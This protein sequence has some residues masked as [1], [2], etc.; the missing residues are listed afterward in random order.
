MYIYNMYIYIHTYI[1]ILY[2]YYIIYIKKSKSAPV[3]A[4]VCLSTSSNMSFQHCKKAQHGTRFDMLLSRSSTVDC[5]CRP[6]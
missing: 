1:Y 3:N 2:I 5:Q 4:G 6:W